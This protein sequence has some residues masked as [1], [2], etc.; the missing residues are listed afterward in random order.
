MDRIAG[1][2]L[3]IGNHRGQSQGPDALACGG[4]LEDRA[5]IE[6]SGRPVEDQQAIRRGVIRDILAIGSVAPDREEIELDAGIADVDLEDPIHVIITDEQVLRRV[7]VSESR[8][9]AAETLQAGAVIECP[10]WLEVKK[11]V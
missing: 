9:L 5:R 10:A 7:D 6:G 2:R 1:D 4:R 11:V 8:R 3:R